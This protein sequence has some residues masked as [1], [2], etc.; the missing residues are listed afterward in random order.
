MPIKSIKNWKALS[1]F[2]LLL[3]IILVF[4]LVY[5]VP[6]EFNG[7]SITKWGFGRLIWE[8][9]EWGIFLNDHHQL[10]W[11]VMIPQVLL[12]SL[13]PEGYSSYYYTPILAFSL[14]TLGT[15][16]LVEF[17]KSVFVLPALLLVVISIEPLS[18]AMAS[19]VN[20]GAFGLFA[21]IIGIYFVTAYEKG[22][23]YLYLCIG[24]GFF[25]CAYGSHVTYLMFSAAP[26]VYLA[27]NRK[28]IKAVIVFGITLILLFFVELTVFN[29]L[30]HGELAGGRLAR[31][32]EVKQWGSSR[33]IGSVRLKG[34]DY[35]ELQDFFDRWRQ[36]PKYSLLI[37]VMFVVSSLRLLSRKY[38]DRMP[39]TVWLMFYS[40]AAYGL[41]VSFPIIGIKPLELALDLHSRYLAPFFPLA[42]VFVVW[43]FAELVGYR[44]NIARSTI[45]IAAFLFLTT[46]FLWGSMN[47]RCLEEILP[48]YSNTVDTLSEDVFCRSFRYSQEQNIYPAPD[49]FV[50][51][52][53]RYYKS[54]SSDYVAGQVSLFGSTR[55]PVFEWVVKI[56]H[57]EAKFKETVNGW[58]S[59]D[60][61][62]KQQ[63]AMELGQF[64]SPQQNYRP[65]LGII[66]SREIFD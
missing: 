36:L 13:F 18:H 54:F 44:S 53:D 45:P 12:A 27:L 63:C 42:S 64:D 58:Y 41:A 21:V 15:I 32:V 50:F 48:G 52:A 55:L 31:I 66:M 3:F 24:A 34:G 16:T 28:N 26:I 51:R 37:G 65:C 9:Q 39:G 49:S 40:A 60:G 46:G 29:L 25:F 61:V 1:V 19:Q 6:I 17:E 62:D 14:F 35:Y 47:Y 8:T 2:F 20:S 38:R 10:R 4:R 23:N 56:T 59:I 30:S 11:F 57:P 5:S 33:T 22:N 7:E 43:T